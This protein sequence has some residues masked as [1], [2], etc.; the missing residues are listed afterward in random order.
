MTAVINLVFSG[1]PDFANINKNYL[2]INSNWKLENH[3][4]IVASSFKSK[5]PICPLA[6]PFKIFP[7]M[8]VMMKC[9]VIK[10]ISNA[11]NNNAM[12]NMILCG[13]LERPTNV[14]A[15]CFY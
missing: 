12:L 10:K 11:T 15:S 5:P 1:S 2:L 13:R 4:A 7:K 9:M 14:V 8:P 6:V 3:T